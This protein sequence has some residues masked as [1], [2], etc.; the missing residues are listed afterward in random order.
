MDHTL[1]SLPIK[2]GGLGILSYKTVAPLAY[3]AASEAADH[4]LA[5]ILTPQAPLA[6]TQLTTL[7]ELCQE[8][9]NT[10][11]DALLGS[12]DLQQA[13]AVVEASSKLGR[14]WLTTI[15]FQPLFQL[16]D[17][18]IT[19]AL[20]LRTLAGERDKHCPHCGEPN[21]FGHHEV[22]LHRRL[23]RV[24]R[25]EQ[26]KHVIGQAL[27]TIP[28]AKVKLEPFGHHTHRRNDIQLITLLG[29]QA[30][31]LANC[32]YDL[33][34]ISLASKN[35]RNTSLPENNNDP[36]KLANKHLNSIAQYKSR[37]R[38]NSTLPFHPLVFSLGGM[39]SKCTT[40]QFATWKRAIPRASYSF[41]IRRLSLCLLRA[42]VQS[43]EI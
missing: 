32:E 24:T 19:A 8:V 22:C 35:S 12:L 36:S 18:E 30:V 6:S 20:Q 38:P 33:T 29:S 4:T 17:F 15:P 3:A 31:G 11:R 27:S 7:H 42:R 5:P 28:G 37:Y 10:T 26:A 21:F 40:K 43:F 16:T 1:I 41:M 9:F 39:K 34:V 2:M 14:T 13:K 25:H 23:Y